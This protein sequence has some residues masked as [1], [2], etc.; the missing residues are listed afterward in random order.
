VHGG[1][2]VPYQIGRFRHGWDV[3]AEPHRRMRGTP[4]DS[5]A[6]M[7]FDTITHDDAALDYLVGKV[8]ADRI[9]FGTDYPFDMGDYRGV[10]RI[11]RLG[12]SAADEAALLGG[13]I[14]KLL[15]KAPAAALPHDAGG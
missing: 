3:R 11:R 1:G 4:E 5:F 7:M 8:G 10:E 13:T 6:R 9:V 14:D 12:L 2:F 15:Q